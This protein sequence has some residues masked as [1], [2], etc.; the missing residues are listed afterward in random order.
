MID[1]MDELDKEH[2]EGNKS[3]RVERGLRHGV[4]LTENGLIGGGGGPDVFS[5]A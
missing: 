4:A 1:C 3:L 2:G 5:V